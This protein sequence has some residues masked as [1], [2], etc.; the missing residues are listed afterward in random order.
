MQKTCGGG[1]IA[2]QSGTLF[3]MTTQAGVWCLQPNGP[4]PDFAGRF[5]V[6]N[7]LSYIVDSGVTTGVDVES[8][9]K[10]IEIGSGENRTQAITTRLRLID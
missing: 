2:T 8:T 7:K 5:D 9:A 10:W 1:S 3:L 4:H 6:E